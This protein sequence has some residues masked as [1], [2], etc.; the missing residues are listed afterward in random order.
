[1]EATPQKYLSTAEAADLWKV[2]PQTLR[3]AICRDGHYFGIRPIKAKN[4]FLLW[5]ENEVNRL[6]QEGRN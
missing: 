2:Q 5:P 4:R 6:L 1:M 3:A